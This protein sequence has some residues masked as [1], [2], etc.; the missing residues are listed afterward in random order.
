LP[1]SRLLLRDVQGDLLVEGKTLAPIF[2][3]VKGPDWEGE[4][5]GE[6]EKEEFFERKT[7][8]KYVDGEGRAASPVEIPFKVIRHNALKKF[9]DDRPNMVVIVDDLM[10]S[11]AVARGIIDGQVREFLREPG[12]AR[13]GAILFLRPECPVGEPVRYLSNF[14]DN[15]AA[16]SA[17]QLP[18]DAVAVLKDRAEQDS[19]I[20]QAEANRWADDP[21][22]TLEDLATKLCSGA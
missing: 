14:Y 21:Q 4:F 5:E 19:A 3:E 10:L 9:A 2:I 15:P 12:S 17:C 6:L 16:L 7:L 22:R 18:E 20:V 11:P 1:G 8:G 13:L